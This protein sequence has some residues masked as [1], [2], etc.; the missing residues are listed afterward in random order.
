MLESMRKT[1][2]L[3]ADY[4]VVVM[5]SDSDDGSAALLAAWQQQDPGRVTVISR[6]IFGEGVRDRS[7]R[8]VALAA[9]RNMLAS[10]IYGMGSVREG[11]S[12]DV[13]VMGDL[14]FEFGWDVGGVASVFR[15][16]DEDAAA[17]WFGSTHSP[18][19]DGE[20]RPPRGA[21]LSAAESDEQFAAEVAS[22]GPRCPPPRPGN[23]SWAYAWDVAAAYGQQAASG[24]VWDWAALRLRGLDYGNHIEARSGSKWYPAL[25]RR[26]RAPGLP[27]MPV[28]CAFGGLAV[29][30]AAALATGQWS[31]DSSANGCEHAGLCTSMAMHGFR[32]VFVVPTMV[33]LYDLRG[34]GGSWLGRLANASANTARS[35]PKGWA[36]GGGLRVQTGD[37]EFLSVPAGERVRIPVPPAVV[38]KASTKTPASEQ[39]S[40]G[41][42]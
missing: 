8:T 32:R 37:S 2:E 23:A 25:K 16:H 9:M 38:P 18:V 36:K 42:P 21:I 4:R 41:Q 6:R 10:V 22:A 31:G 30:R 35:R 33:Q 3:F 7:D 40:A 27:W 15:P 17:G 28:R 5:E 34:G 11:F 20:C 13:V 19:E 39:A 14:D 24:F 26:L 12:F 1:G 29:F